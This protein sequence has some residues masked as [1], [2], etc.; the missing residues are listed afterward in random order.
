MKKMLCVI[1]V[2]ILAVGLVG[3]GKGA[4]TQEGAKVD[5]PTKPITL[6]VSF[7]AGGGTDLGARLL[8]P[9]LEKELGVPVVVENKPG[10]GGWIGY[11]ELLKAKPDGYTIGY[12]N[13]PGLITGYLNPSAK[14]QQNLDSFTYVANH[15]LDPGVIAVRADEKRFT[16]IQELIEYA[17]KQELTT[18]T[19]GVGTGPHM[20]AL[21][22]NQK[23]G[24]KFKPV[25]FN[26]TGEYLA[27]VLGGHIDVFIARVGESLEP[28]RD[29]QLKVLAVTTKERVPQYPNVPTMNETVGE[30]LNYSSRGIAAPKGIDPKVLEKLQTAFEKAMKNPE[31]VQKMEK[32]GL[33]VHYL[34][35][36]DY[37][38]LLKAEEKVIQN[39]K[40]LLGWN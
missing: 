24:T 37:K 35:G 33:T 31:H 23:M 13:T 11:S 28:V 20:A 39:L 7:A 2:L 36:D 22:I 21:D 14:R 40:P 8:A 10:G 3:C 17:K 12:V 38:N 32:M 30:V 26:G 19:N 6:I 34:K 29:G 18:T 1:M 9:Y 27:A 25:H 16:T 15:V 4:K 5:F